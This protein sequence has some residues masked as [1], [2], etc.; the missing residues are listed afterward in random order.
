LIHPLLQSGIKPVIIILPAEIDKTNL[1][2]TLK[3]MDS[4]DDTVQLQQ[5]ITGSGQLA[6]EGGVNSTKSTASSM[7]GKGFNNLITNAIDILVKGQNQQQQNDV[8][9]NGSYSVSAATLATANDNKKIGLINSN[10]TPPP[11][12]LVRSGMKLDLFVLPLRPLP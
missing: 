4:S 3:E 8:Q 2:E 5:S 12:L 1:I 10:M 6:A 9:P 7:L 11:L